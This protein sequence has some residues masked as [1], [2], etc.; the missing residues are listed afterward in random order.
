MA[1]Y[2]KRFVHSEVSG[3]IVLLACTII[4][5][6]WAN[7]PWAESYQHML[8][9]KAG[10][11]VGGHVFTLS[12]HHWVNDGLMVVF[13]FVVGLEIKRELVVGRLSSLDRAILPVTAAV[14]GMVVPALLYYALNHGGP[15]AA[16]W[17]VPMAT[18][19]AFALGLLAVFGKRVPIGLKVFLMALAIA[20]D[21]GAV[22]VIAIYYTEK[23]NVTALIVA[24]VL[25]VVL[26]GFIKA[27][28]NR[29]GLLAMLIVAF[30]AAV[31]VSGIHA[32]IAGILVALLVPV[33]SSIEPDEFMGALR[34]S[35]DELETGT[36]LTRDSMIEESAQLAAIDRVWTA[37]ER[38][39]P[40][41]LA[42]EHYLHPAQAFFVLPLFAL[43]NAGVTLTGD[44]GAVLA[45]RE[46]LGV[47]VGLF[48]GKQLGV[49]GFTW[50]AVKSGRAHLPE[51]V[52]FGHVWGVSALA[53]IGFTMSLFVSDL[54]FKAPELL[55]GAKLGIL[56][57]SLLSGTWGAI[58]L[59]RLLPRKAA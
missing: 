50:L 22:A 36:D 27:R 43:F 52:T 55:A 4:A 26:A 19:I 31:L 53:G 40:S 25:L 54:A 6:V 48:L 51:G 2:F 32:T 5:L 8:H 47:I 7:S 23:I 33:K 10:I 16:G 29:V 11:S 1:D 30:W 12:L 15:A 57:A 13:F 9:I 28:I 18:D 44:V 38:M 45:T 56:V 34:T 35:L 59:W 39:Y 21:L 14:G 46:A 41:G 24:A 37:G 3:S 42:L 17:G 58:L 49:F 20:D